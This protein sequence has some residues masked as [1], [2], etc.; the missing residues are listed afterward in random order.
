MKNKLQKDL[1]SAMKAGNKDVTETLRSVLSAISVDE[2]KEGKILND[3]DVLKI[4]SKQVKDRK[5]SSQ[6][7]LD[8][9]RTDLFIKEQKQIA[10]I[11]VYLPKALTTEEVETIIKEI[12]TTGSYGKADMGKVI[13][14][15]NSK[16]QGQADGKT[17]SEIVKL[18]LN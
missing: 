17:V 16:Y 6:M 1:T 15:F 12:I 8:A 7:F 18:N 14:E 10:I 2:K 13:K 3:S 9:G 11:E 4:L 5:T